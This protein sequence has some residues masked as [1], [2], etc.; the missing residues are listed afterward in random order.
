MSALNTGA[1]ITADAVARALL[2]GAARGKATVVPSLG[3][4]IMRWFAGAAPG[5]TARLMDA[6]IARAQRA[7][8]H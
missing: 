8:R 7:S 3:S 6:I 1:P 5:P 4:R 2:T